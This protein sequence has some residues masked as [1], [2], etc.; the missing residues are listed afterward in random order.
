ML[1]AREKYVC[2]GGARGGGKSWAVRTKAILAALHYAGI[3]V[4]IVR[5]T[6]PELKANHID[7]MLQVLGN[8]GCA[9]YNTQ[10]KEYRFVNGSK[11]FFGY[12]GSA[13]DMLRYQGAE[14]DVIFL[15]EATQWD[16]DIFTKF[17]AC[18]RGVNSFPKRIYLTC[19]PGGRGH[20]WV[21][22]LFVDRRFKDGEKPE[23]Y[24]FIQSLVTDNTALMAIQPEYLRQLDNLPSKL[25]AAWRYGDWNVFEGQYFEEFTDDPKHYLDQ[26][27][28]HVIAPFEV[29]RSWRRFRSFDW[30][31]G[32][33]FSCGWWAADFEG[34]LYRIAELYGCGE[35]PNEGVKWTPDKAFTEIKRIEKEHPLLAGTRI[36]GIA[37][38]AIWDGSSDQHGVC[39]ADMAA[40]MGIY[41]EPGNHARIP[42]WMQVHYRL[43][44]DEGGRPRMYVFSTCKAFIR[45]IPLLV[46]S[47][48]RP[49][50][51]DTEQEDHV[52]DEVRYLCM[53]NPITPP[54]YAPRKPR[55]YSPL[56]LNEDS[57]PDKYAFFKL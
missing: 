4:L 10:N 31:Y 20:A 19:N 23:E 46:Y 22:R 13:I 43:A 38:P 29:P 2:F 51:L 37:D 8:K 18:L 36:E 50:D 52:A 7:P 33:P 41:F 5:R 53:R 49:E 42:G 3:R 44:F 24:S 14:Y 54:E 55:P 45:T 27:F 32:K 21:K 39:I 1:A 40:R 16:E 28:T 9:H 35:T 6:Y 11:I 56:D 17:R 15:E 12:C 57:T 48:K 34:I 30:G 26:R 25:R 47:E